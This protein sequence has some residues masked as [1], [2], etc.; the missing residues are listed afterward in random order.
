MTSRTT[1]VLASLLAVLCALPALTAPSLA[2]DITHQLMLRDG[3]AGVH[4]TPFDL[5]DFVGAPGRPAARL[6]E[7]GAIPWF[8]SPN[9]RFRFFR[10]LSSASL[11][12]DYWLFG[13]R[14]WALRLD[15][16]AWFL[17]AIGF[18]A[19]LYRRILAPGPAVLA[20]ILY[21]GASGH[22]VPLSWAAARHTVL[23][24][25]L[26]LAAC[27]CY[28]RG[29]EG[30]RPGRWLG[31]LVFVA[32]LCASE[33][34]LGAVAIIAAW[35]LFGRREPLI[36]RIR[37]L[38]PY[39]A[40]AAAYL[41]FY[42]GAG[43]GVRESAVYLD[44]TAG[45]SGVASMIRR[46]G[47]LVGEMAT[48]VPADLV[49]GRS[50]HVQI[51]AAVLGVLALVVIAGVLH[52]ARWR[53]RPG[54]MR[55]VGWCVAAALA[56]TLPGTLTLAS[57]RTLAL[58]LVPSSA[59]MAIVIVRGL[60]A[61]RASAPGLAR[62]AAAVVAGGLA[63][64]LVAGGP[65]FRVRGALDLARVARAQRAL[66]SELP[67]CAGTLVIV[68][69]S[70]PSVS[71][72]APA[73]LALRGQP[74]RA[75]RVLSMAPVRLRIEHVTA[76]G[77]NLRS[78]DGRPPTV[79]DRIYRSDPVPAGTRVSLPEFEVNVLDG[80][81][82]DPEAFWEGSLVHFDFG[83]PLDSPDLCFVQWTHGQ[84]RPMAPPRPGD[85]I[86]IPPQFG[87]VGW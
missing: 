87:P 79:Q 8:A 14:A 52:Y 45:V 36:R 66:A 10:P 65:F 33:M 23:G 46:L 70:D 77:F 1:V 82:V 43:Y 57:G 27:W 62:M 58:A 60:Q 19:A 83:E 67:P 50:V 80:S 13:S 7:T 25:A 55:T 11:A 15:S 53:V 22:V 39:G 24:A 30:W 21:A 3:V 16:L 32:D 2:D 41:A 74:F 17:I 59:A 49:G 78:L 64:A 63:I 71:H 81:R 69:G 26:A 85:V 34:A 9:L 75:L 37:E 6:Q 40:I 35:E 31:P 61:A 47:I 76:T 5:Y 42:V 44:P 51:M 54:E 38:L 18:A 68:N 29:R 73:M 12:V 86:D 48:S 72:V 28:A 20:T 84:I 4:W 56:A